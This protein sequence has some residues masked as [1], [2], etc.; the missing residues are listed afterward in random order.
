METKTFVFTLCLVALGYMLFQ[1]SFFEK[2]NVVAQPSP[3]VIP[4]QG[5]NLSSMVPNFSVNVNISAKTRMV[6]YVNT[7]NGISMLYPSDWQSSLAGLSFPEI[8]R[9]YSPLQNI[10]D[11]IPAQITIGVTKYTS[12]GITLPQYTSFVL[13]LLNK[14]QEQKQLTVDNSN[15]I[16]VGGN[17]GYRVTFT[18][19]PS[20]NSTSQLRTMEIWTIV[21]NK[22]YTISYVAEP[23]KFATYL[24]KV[25]GMLGSLRIA[26]IPS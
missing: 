5:K 14:S 3:A 17:P 16:V 13:T 21:D 6:T 10:S 19:S 11:F 23:S 24:P 26:R 15:P 20:L 2:S 12:N 9:F 4:F 25:T 1:I 18:S 8:I 7:L 22:L